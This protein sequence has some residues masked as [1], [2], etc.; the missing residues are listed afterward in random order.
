MSPQ[1]Q[2]VSALALAAA[3]VAW[4]VLRSVSRRRRGGCGG[5]CAC[6]STELKEKLRKNDGKG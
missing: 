4:L 1:I 3:A 2:T 5:E 6:P